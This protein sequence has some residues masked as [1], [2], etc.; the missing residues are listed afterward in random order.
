VKV[1][2][3]IPDELIERC[4]KTQREKSAIMGHGHLDASGRAALAAVLREQAEIF[5]ELRPLI[6]VAARPLSLALILA[7]FDASDEAQ[8]WAERAERSRRREARGEGQ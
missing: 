8:E 2:I 6:P 7:K 5:D 4:D 3:D 1:T